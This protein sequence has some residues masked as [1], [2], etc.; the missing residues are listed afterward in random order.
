LTNILST[1]EQ[2]Y[3]T[4]LYFTRTLPALLQILAVMFAVTSRKVENVT[5]S[6]DGR[7]QWYSESLRTPKQIICTLPART[8]HSHD[9]RRWGSAAPNSPIWWLTALQIKGFW[10]EWG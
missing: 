10:R 8:S 3:F 9:G 1:Q 5:K 7:H 2:N 6:H 4:L